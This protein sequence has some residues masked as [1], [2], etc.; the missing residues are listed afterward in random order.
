VP[1][2]NANAVV[3]VAHACLLT[4][5]SK[6]LMAAQTTQAMV[7]VFASLATTQ[8]RTTKRSNAHRVSMADDQNNSV[9]L[10]FWLIDFR[11]GERG[12]RQ[13]QKIKIVQ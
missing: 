9:P 12:G 3:H 5:S 10:D 11:H 8:R 1:A 13:K 6:S 7:N 2:T 4:M